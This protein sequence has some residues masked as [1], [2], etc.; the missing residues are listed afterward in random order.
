MEPRPPLRRHAKGAA[1]TEAV[2]RA[3]VRG[4]ELPEGWG[5]VSLGELV[6]PSKEKVEPAK[7]PDSPYLSLEHIESGTAK[8]VG[9]GKGADVTSTKAVFRGGDLLYG[10]L[11]PYLNK[12]CIPDFDGIC[13]TDILVFP[14]S[15]FIDNR[16]LLGFLMQSDVVEFANHNSNG[17][18]LP[19]I[20]F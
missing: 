14:K 9:Q 18:Q 12:V 7:R 17:I 2:P 10:K 15:P 3:A 8:V 4:G 5:S 13:S 6:S 19:R 20:S 1:G 11:R 16:F